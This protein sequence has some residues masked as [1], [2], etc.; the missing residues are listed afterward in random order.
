MPVKKIKPHMRHMPVCQHLEGWWRVL[1][2]RT[3]RQRLKTKL[4]GR[5]QSRKETRHCVMRV[6]GAHFQI[7]DREDVAGGGEPT[8]LQSKGP[9][10]SL[11]VRR[12]F[13]FLFCEMT[14]ITCPNVSLRCNN[15]EVANSVSG[16]C[17]TVLSNASVI[18][19][20]HH[21]LVLFS[22]LPVF[23]IFR[24]KDDEG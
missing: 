6:W 14:L 17:C 23:E 12:S 20:K 15:W 16:Q 8:P 1:N 19:A 22:F 24:R 2:L 10:Q 4:E 11:W 13:V 9:G 18:T 21:T 7:F 3:T 5:Q